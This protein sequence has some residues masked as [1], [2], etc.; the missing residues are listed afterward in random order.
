MARR[1]WFFTEVGR[2]AKRLAA[3]RARVTNAST[4]SGIDGKDASLGV[5][6]E[7]SSDESPARL[8][9][10]DMKRQSSGGVK[11]YRIQRWFPGGQGV[12]DRSHCRGWFV[13]SLLK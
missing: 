4:Y 5:S 10:S 8:L 3:W 11:W 12:S 13:N 2:L 9:C 6:A 1:A 7:A